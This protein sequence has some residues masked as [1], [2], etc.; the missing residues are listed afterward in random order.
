MHEKGKQELEGRYLEV[1]PALAM[2]T[3]LLFISIM[4]PDIILSILD[5]WGGSATI[6]ILWTV[7]RSKSKILSV[8]TMQ[9]VRKVQLPCERQAQG[10][11][12]VDVLLSCPILFLNDVRRYLPKR[13]WFHFCA[14]G[15]YLLNKGLPLLQVCTW[16][17]ACP[18]KNRC[19]NGRQ[20]LAGKIQP[21]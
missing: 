10:R 13:I 1:W 6:N 3:E 20:E 2:G 14:S 19:S 21:F 15:M 12:S 4:Q 16:W 17:I 7:L 8:T 9:R 18:R 5:Q 11:E